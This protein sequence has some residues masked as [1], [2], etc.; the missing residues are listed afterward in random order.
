MNTLCRP[1][2]YLGVS[3]PCLKVDLWRGFAVLCA[4]RREQLDFIV[5]PTRKIEGVE[6]IQLL[7]DDAPLIFEGA[8]GERWR[9]SETTSR[10]LAS[11]DVAMAINSKDTRGQDQLHIHL[12]CVADSVR[13]YFSQAPK[14]G[15][16][17]W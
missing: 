15:A 13:D 10:R 16:G 3:F 17:N 1:L 9:L 6:S 4:P 8:W 11:N 2:V 7:E 5:T 12:G 14:L